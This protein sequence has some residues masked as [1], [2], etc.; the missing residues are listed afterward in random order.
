[1]QDRLQASTIVV[2]VRVDHDDYEAFSKYMATVPVNKL[3]RSLDLAARGAC[4]VV[5][6]LVGVGLFA[7]RSEWGAWLMA[8]SAIAY[9]KVFGLVAQRRCRGTAPS[10][11]GRLTIGPSGLTMDKP[12]ASTHVRWEGVVDAQVA[13]RHVFICTGFQRGFVVPMRCFEPGQRDVFVA[14]LN[15]GRSTRP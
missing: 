4:V 14:Q 3:P 7:T 11:D 13:P 6:I 9:A 15:E 12:E 5:S 1:M 10:F 8:L 2:D